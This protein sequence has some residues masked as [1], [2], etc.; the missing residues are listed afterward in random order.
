MNASRPMATGVKLTTPNLLDTPRHPVTP[1]MEQ[2]ADARA[3][4]ESKDFTLTTDE[5]ASVAL[6]SFWKE[7]PVVLVMMKDGC[8]CTMEAQPHF[9]DLASQFGKDINFVGVIDADK[10]TASKFR[11]DFSCPFPVLSSPNTDFFKLWRS[12]QS[13]Y[14]FVIGVGGKVEMVWP[15]YNK[16]M[17]ASLNHMLSELSKKP[18]AKLDMDM[19]P[20]KMTSGC[21]FFMP[22]G[23]SKPA[24]ED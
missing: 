8:P 1:Q 5:G 10:E 9:N 23:T 17:L 6:S 16:K 20:E 11:A 2:D 15:G 21:Y 7:K 3:G 24:W 14:T 12:K 19:V 22:V 13:V 4:M 18:E